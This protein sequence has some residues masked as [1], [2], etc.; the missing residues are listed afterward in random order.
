MKL[1]VNYFDWQRRIVIPHLGR[2][3][4]EIGCGMGNFTKHLLDRESVIA[5]DA[6]PACIDAHRAKFGVYPNVSSCVQDVLDPAFLSLKDSLPDSIVCLNVLEHVDGH[7]AALRQMYAVLPDG[8]RVVLIVPAFESLYGPI[9]AL[10]G[11][12]RRYSKRSLRRAAESAGFV[13]QQLRYMNSI[14]FFGW[15]FNARILRATEQTEGQIRFFDSKIVPFLAA[16]ESIVTPPFGQSLFA[17]LVKG[18]A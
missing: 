16:M 8:G 3:V 7:L 18:R 2:R 5:I 14:G 9:D 10:L 1:A 13:P 4:L 12:Y 6:E 15:W 11:H 17:V